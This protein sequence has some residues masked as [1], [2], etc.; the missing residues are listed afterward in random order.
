MAQ[1]LGLALRSSRRALP[2]LYRR[3]FS[4]YSRQVAVGQGDA[5]TS[6]TAEVENR[7]LEWE[8]NH[9]KASKKQ[10]SKRASLRLPDSYLQQLE[11]TIAQVLPVKLQDSYLKWEDNYGPLAKD[12]RIH[13]VQLRDACKC[14]T[15]VDQ[16]S[17]Q[18]NFRT[19]DIPSWIQPRTLEWKDGSLTVQWHNDI[20]SYPPTHT[21]TYSIDDL[22]ALTMGIKHQDMQRIDRNRRFWTRQIMRKRQHWISYDDYMN[23]ELKFAVA[24]RSL[25]VYGI[26]FVK[27]IPESRE[28]VEKIATRMGPL[29]N[30]FYGPT[31]DVRS[32]PKAKNVAYTNQFLGF[33]MDLLYMNE[34][35]GYQ[36]L[37]CLQNSC[38]GGESLFSDALYAAYVVRLVAPEYY[39][40]LCSF[41][42]GYEY[43]HENHVYSN[44]WPVVQ[45]SWDAR[46]Q[47]YRVNYSPPFQSPLYLDQRD[48]ENFEK[49]KDAL[50]FF[51]RIMENKKSSFELKLNPGECV[52]FENRRIVHARRQFNTES[53]H[54]WLAGAY[55]DDD[56]VRSTIHVCQKKYPSA[57]PPTRG[58]S[59]EPESE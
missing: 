54:R 3:S 39:K 21:S 25:A 18:R 28:M 29:R 13:Y 20:K 10:E 23:D 36:L 31:W 56:A 59:K 30:T 57:F 24:M 58:P 17:K 35:P 49:F 4:V 45:A 43:R 47:P 5:A 41:R 14:P 40:A 12:E 51:T 19:T 27:D 32:V 11:Q 8:L 52:I 38:E 22:R 50:E 15:C 6:T 48:Q 37:H 55:V 16:H 42:L 9:W 2:S 1:S 26:L 34:P 46:A 33:H 44:R 7:S 53:G